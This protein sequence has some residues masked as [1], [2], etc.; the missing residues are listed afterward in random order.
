M[1]NVEVYFYTLFSLL[2][3]ESGV[4]FLPSLFFDEYVL[5]LLY[6]YVLELQ[7]TLP[8]SI[9]STINGLQL[10]S[11]IFPI[12]EQFNEKHNLAFGW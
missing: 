6:C 12:D 9:S 4:H 1:V 7:L 11:I 2:S 10:D 5:Y 3:S 8:Q